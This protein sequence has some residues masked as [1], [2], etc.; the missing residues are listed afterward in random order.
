MIGWPHLFNGHELGQT[1]G[2]G[3]WQ[4]GLACCSP[5]G[6]RVGHD[7]VTEQQLSRQEATRSLRERIYLVEMVTTRA[8][9]VKFAFPTIVPVSVLIAQLFWTV[10]WNKVVLLWHQVVLTLLLLW[11]GGTWLLPHTKSFPL[12]CVP[13]LITFKKGEYSTL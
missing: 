5:W 13:V 12:Y 4:E 3:E 6:H 9:E 8:L 10:L 2:D 7:L 1:P 11:L